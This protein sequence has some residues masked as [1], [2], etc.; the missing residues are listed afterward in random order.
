M[1][2]RRKFPMQ[3]FRTA[4]AYLLNLILNTVSAAARTEMPADTRIMVTNS[5]DPEAYPISGFTWIILY[6]DL[7]YNG[8]TREQAAAVVNFLDWLIGPEGQAIAESVNYAPLPSDVSET[9]KN[10]SED[11]NI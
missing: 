1:P 10:N 2:L 5:P 3:V 8:R 9:A 4:Q 7:A 6:K 11:S